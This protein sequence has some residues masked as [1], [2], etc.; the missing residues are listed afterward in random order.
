[1]LIYN[2][3]NWSYWGTY[4]PPNYLGNQKVTFDGENKLIIVN[5]GE[6]DIDVRV[7]VYSAWKEWLLFPYL[8]NTKYEQ[9]MSAVGG[10]PLPGARLLGSTFFLENGWK[11]RTWEG[12]HTLNVVGNIFSRDGSPLFV[13]TLDKWTVSINLTTSTLVETIVP[14]VAITADDLVSITDS[15]WGYDNGTGTDIDT[16]ITNIS[17]D[18]SAVANN[19]W[20]QIIDT[21]KSQSAGDKL[22]KIATKTQDI[23]LS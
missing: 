7:D 1:M 9:A 15:V 19:V 18:V 21:D 17:T 10:D 5:Y 8:N 13:S 23:A 11:M 3:Y 16:R 12:N 22:K 6:T 20:D 2:F 4:A 14:E